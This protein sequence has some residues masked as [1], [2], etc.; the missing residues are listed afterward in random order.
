MLT[1]KREKSIDPRLMVVRSFRGGMQ[2]VRAAQA[3]IR[4][5]DG[6]NAQ[7]HA[8]GI[9]SRPAHTCCDIY[10]SG[11]RKYVRALR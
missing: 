10:L 7:G 11:S 3:A 4:R 8:A 9:P 1:S 2:G 6:G 5:R